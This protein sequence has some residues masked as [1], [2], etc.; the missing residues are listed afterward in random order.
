VL[1]ISQDL[2]ELFAIADRLAVI[3]NGALSPSRPTR[4]WTREEI[5]LAMMG[6]AE[7]IAHAA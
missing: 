1:V 5:G 7:D 3:H 6:L 4:T 2:D